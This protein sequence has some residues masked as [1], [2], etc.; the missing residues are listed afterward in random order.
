MTIQ[1]GYGGTIIASGNLRVVFFFGMSGGVFFAPSNMVVDGSFSVTGGIFYHNNGTIRMEGAGNST[2]EVGSGVTLYNLTIA[3][4][5]TNNI[6]LSSGNTLTVANDFTVSIGTFNAGAGSII[7]KDLTQTITLPNSTTFIAPSGIMRISGNIDIDEFA[8]FQHNNGTVELNGGIATIEMP[9]SNNFFYNLKINKTSTDNILNSFLVVA[10][11]LE[12]IDGNLQP[13][14][15]TNEPTNAIYARGNVFIYDSYDSDAGSTSRLIMNGGGAQSITPSGAVTY[16]GNIE[17]K[18]TSGTTIIT[19]SGTNVLEIESANFIFTAGKVEL[20]GEFIIGASAGIMM[21]NASR[22]FITTGAGKLS[23]VYTGS[24]F[25]NFPVGSATRYAPVGIMLSGATTLGVAYIPAPTTLPANTMQTGTNNNLVRRSVNEVW[26]MSSSVASVGIEPYMYVSNA[27][28]SNI[29]NPNNLEIAIKNGTSDWFSFQNED[30]G[31]YTAYSASPI[32]G[33]LS[34]PTLYGF[35]DVVAVGSSFYLTYGSRTTADNFL[36]TNGAQ[37]V[38]NCKDAIPISVATNTNVSVSSNYLAGG[39]AVSCDVSNVVASQWYEFT[40]T[41]EVL[42]LTYQNTSS[43]TTLEL[44]SGGCDALTSLGCGTATTSMAGAYINLFFNTNAGETYKIRL[45]TTS[46]TATGILR[47]EP[48]PAPVIIAPVLGD[49][50]D[51]S[52]VAK[53][54]AVSEATDYQ[55]EIFQGSNFGNVYVSVPSTSGFTNYTVSGLIAGTTYHYRVR[56][57]FVSGTSSDYSSMQ[58]ITVV[59]PAPTLTVDNSKATSTSFKLIFP[60]PPTTGATHYLLTITEGGVP[61]SYNQNGTIQPFQDISPTGIVNEWEIKIGVTLTPNTKYQA[62]LKAANA[63]GNS[64]PITVDAW[65]APSAPTSI[66]HSATQITAT[67][68]W[69]DPVGSISLYE[70]NINGGGWNTTAKPANL[71]GLTAGAFY[72]IEVRVTAPS[73]L[74]SVPSTVYGITTLPFPPNSLTLTNATA[75]GFDASWADGGGATSYEYQVAIDAGF[76]TIVL[77]GSTNFT[78][79]T[80]IVTGGQIYYF[81][82]R[83][84]NSGGESDYVDSFIDTPPAPPIAYEATGFTAN[85]FIAQWQAVGG[86]TEYRLDVSTDVAFGVGTFVYENLLV[87]STN[88]TQTVTVT[89]T[90]IMYYYQVRTV[91]GVD[92]SGNSNAIT[93]LPA[94]AGLNITDNKPDGFTVNWT[95]TPPASAEYRVF[96]A[97]SSA[98]NIAVFTGSS[99]SSPIIVSG[100]S[101]CETYNVS[102]YAVSS[103]APIAPIGF[104]ATTTSFTLP[105]TPTLNA[106]T[107]ITD[108]GVTFT[109]NAVSCATSYTL[110]YALASIPP[111][112]SPLIISGIVGTS[113]NITDLLPIRQIGWL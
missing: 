48:I 94:P 24:G 66:S 35:G 79:V 103:L 86:A 95:S 54:N 51:N 36:G 53:W 101:G 19:S 107:G 81:R 60:S 30:L 92:I 3:K 83:A 102:L 61:I 98:P 91:K 34:L 57:I 11:D 111:F 65:T 113:Q 29:S 75:N 39:S 112:A 16:Y 26:D 7:T 22:Y 50:T 96:V 82:V 23:H 105:A 71:T 85:S 59:P 77:S 46:L 58:S 76:S 28:A 93:A 49:A 8:I 90:G 10:N 70:I 88:T 31:R 14:N 72:G 4:P 42:K 12:L 109:W 27:T 56:A 17:N 43:F 21:P 74:T 13:A 110:R 99:S 41:G 40:G 104:L 45:A 63:M 47:I 52:F 84:V 67:I 69:V 5:I 73:N 62:T 106:I 108:T 97:T 15:S 38:T 87:P 6:T 2:L 20:Q 78:S 37:R 55:I 18:K 100:L 33:G 68:D 89:D 80:P 9:G 64:A 1:G 25:F 32:N 44:F